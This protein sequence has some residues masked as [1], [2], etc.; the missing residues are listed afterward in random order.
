MHS[1]NDNNICIIAGGGK[2]P[3][4]IYNSLN[5]KGYNISIIGIKYNFNSKIKFLNIEIIKIGSIS[6]ILK[7]LK[8]NNINK[9]IFAGSIKRPSLKD[10]SLDFEAIKLINTTNLDSVGD[11]K[12]FKKIA[13]Y[14]EKKGFKFINWIN[15]C[16]EIFGQIKSLTIKK[17]SNLAQE[18]LKKGLD[19]FKHI[20]KAD[21]GQSII[22]QNKI[23]LGIESIEG[24]DDLI[25][26]CNKYKRKGDKGILLK[27]KKN[28]QDLRFDL[29]TIG[30]NTLKILKKY[31]YEGIYIQS[32]YCIIIE[33]NKVI[34]FANKNNLFINCI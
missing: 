29:P 28:N 26:R 6:K 16:P 13:I 11:D 3:V 20:G 31:N 15:Y 7:F 12:L 19:V 8:K 34:N 24:T 5:N 10:I 9:I 32:K 30:I 2:L 33:K 14:F 23:I 4:L 1:L 21:I 27:L 22:I 17:P 25:K 18:N